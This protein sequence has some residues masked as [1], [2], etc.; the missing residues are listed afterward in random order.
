MIVGSVCLSHSP[1]KDRTRP[2][3]EIEARFDAALSA[4]ATF[5]AEQE[6]GLTII[7]YPDHINGFFYGLLP[8]FC[9]GIEGASIGDYG[10]AAGKMCIAED[11][12]SD[13]ARSVLDSGV[14]VAIS[15][16]MQI[17]HGAV[18]PLE[19]LSEGFPL[20]RIIPIFVNCAAPPLP[21]FARA[22]AL[23]QA[24]GDWA[25]Q[26][27]ERI[28]IIGSGGLSHDPPM[29]QLATA[30][31][32]VRERLIYGSALDHSQ[33]FARQSR[34][35]AEGNAMAV[36]Q[37]RLL[38]PNADWDRKLM[39]AFLAGDLNVHDGYSQ[40][41]ISSVGGRGGHEARTWVAALA[42]L[43]PGYAAQEI[44]CEIVDEWIT[45]MGIVSAIPGQR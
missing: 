2:G 16:D 42:A 7:F 40:H 27:P 33:R 14:D 44:Y 38:P 17:D 1:L 12:A 23:G 11:R 37:S 26:A 22:R 29:A 19:L 18:Q 8:S 25:R 28:L 5:V 20:K 32:E 4:A 43:G 21:T 9:I 3:V 6:P 13:L 45:G 31:P 35:M 39:N 36:G 41:D 10:T 15:H 30:T 24:V 34:A